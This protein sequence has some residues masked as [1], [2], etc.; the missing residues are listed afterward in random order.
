MELNLHC[1]YPVS[2]RGRQSYP[3][4]F[5]PTCFAH[6]SVLKSCWASE[7]SQT[8]LL[9]SSPVSRKTELPYWIHSDQFCSPVYAEFQLSLWNKLNLHCC[10]PVLSQG[11]QATLLNSYRP[12]L[13]TSLCWSPGEPV[14]RVESPLWLSSLGSRKTELPYWIHTDLFCSPVSAEFQLSKWIELNLHC[15]YPVSCPRRQ[16]YFTE[17]ISTCE[18]REA[19]SL[20]PFFI[21]AF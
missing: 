14:N 1:G 4:E 13:L 12:V 7:P 16:S 15:G 5:I 10:Y 19:I 18:A 21:F 9:L 11:R 2:C 6:L 3:T 20:F 17:S 8:P